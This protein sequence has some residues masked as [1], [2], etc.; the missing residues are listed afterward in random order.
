MY[1]L[2]SRTKAGDGNGTCPHDPTPVVWYTYLSN[3]T[4]QLDN[5]T[6]FNCSPG[7][8]KTSVLPISTVFDAAPAPGKILMYSSGSS[9]Q[10]FE[11][12]FKLM[13]E[14]FVLLILGDFGFV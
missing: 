3:G 13:V 12:D 1:N 7:A 10:N 2:S 4:A 6:H 14:E 9:P 5:N 8:L 11:N